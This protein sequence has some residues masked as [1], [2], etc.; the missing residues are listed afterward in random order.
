[1]GLKHENTC[2]NYNIGTTQ[3]IIYFQNNSVYITLKI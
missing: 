1:M 2:K 3:I